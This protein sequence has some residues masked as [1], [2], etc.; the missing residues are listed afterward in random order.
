MLQGN[1]MKA[2]IRPISRLDGSKFVAVPEEIAA[3]VCAV[4]LI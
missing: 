1:S 4:Y 3:G 2:A